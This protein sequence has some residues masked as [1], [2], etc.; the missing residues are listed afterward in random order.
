MREIATPR[1]VID[2]DATWPIRLPKN[3]V[4]NRPAKAAPTKGASGID[5]DGQLL[6]QWSCQLAFEMIE[7][8][9]IN[10]VNLAK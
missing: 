5:R 2:C 7:I 1:I 8:F 6:K 9:G 4:P 3:L 10:R